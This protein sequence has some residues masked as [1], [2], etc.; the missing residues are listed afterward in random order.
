MDDVK[1]FGALRIYEVDPG[2][3]EFLVP[4]ELAK[5]LQRGYARMTLCQP[6]LIVDLGMQVFSRML[7]GNAGAPQI[8]G[9]GFSDIND[10]TV[11]SMRLAATV[12]PAAPASGD[13]ALITPLYTPVLVVTYPDDF[14]VQFG[15]LVPATEAV[16]TTFTQE[17]LVLKN[18]ML[19]AE[20]T[21]SQLKTSS[22]GLQFVHGFTFARGS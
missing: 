12:N 19:F 21:F 17:Q 7:G 5:A 13:T 15:G 14:S 9:I 22:F 2:I 3:E 20:K 8:G 18:G 1:A 11:T 10:I 16:G 4:A 6:N